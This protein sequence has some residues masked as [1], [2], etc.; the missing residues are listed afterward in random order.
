MTYAIAMMK[1][2]P[3]YREKSLNYLSN[4]ERNEEFHG[5]TGTSLENVFVSFGWPDFIILLK[6][7]N[8]E[9]IKE[10]I[11]KLR[12]DI[13]EEIDDNIETSTII[14][15]TLEEIEK[16]KKEFFSNEIVV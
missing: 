15:S 12:D 14:C 6:S 3:S 2:I 5:E 16:R 1:G 7:E 10:A 13:K 8:V 4:L 11:V 9:L